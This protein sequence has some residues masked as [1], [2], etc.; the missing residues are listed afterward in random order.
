MIN[1]E[2]TPEEIDTL[3]YERYHYP[4]PKVQKKIEVLYLK[5]Q[6]LAHQK[7]CKICRISK[8][9]LTTYLQQYQA[10]GLEQL[11][12]RHYAGQ[13]SELQKHEQTLKQYLEANPPHTSAEAQSVIEELTGLK[14][15]PTQVRAFMKREGMRYRKV[16]Y[17]PGKV[18]LPEKQAEQ[19]AFREEHLVPTLEETRKGEQVTLFMDAAH[20]VQG[21]VLG[22]VW[23][24]VRLFVASPSG[25]KRFNVLGALNAVTHEVLTVTNETYINSQSVCM[26]LDKI[27]AHYAGKPITIFLDNA[28]YQRCRLVQDYADKLGIT[29]CFLPA[30]SPNL[31]LIE[32]YWRFVRKNCLYSRYYANFTDFRSSIEQLITSAHFDHRAELETLLTWNFQSFTKVQISTV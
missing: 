12:K 28:R 16:G 29:L 15:S 4:D 2:F 1:L 3:E 9:T 5:S 18:A 30:Y 13:V 24:F 32:R 26:L 27:A 14:R 19:E 8:T 23:C 10:G 6:E 7:I 17:V 20:F 21:A 11:K 31:N 22:M 25:R